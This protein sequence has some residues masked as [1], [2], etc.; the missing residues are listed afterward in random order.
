MITPCFAPVP[1]LPAIKLQ[2]VAPPACSAWVLG[3]WF[4]GCRITGSR[5]EYMGISAGRYS[6]GARVRVAVSR[7]EWWR[8]V[9]APLIRPWSRPV[10]FALPLAARLSPGKVPPVVLAD[11]RGLA[12][13]RTSRYPFSR[14][15]PSSFPAL[16][17][18][19]A[20][21]APSGPLAEA[22]CRYRQPSRSASLVKV[23]TT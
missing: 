15:K 1:A 20:G 5:S 14:R 12:A 3:W 19:L 22:A 23:I 2:A 4:R 18:A 10:P 17:Y 11:T 21:I 6:R 7:W 8:S 9:A 16:P 13:Y